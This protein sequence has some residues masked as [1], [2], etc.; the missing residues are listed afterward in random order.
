MKYGTPKPSIGDSLPLHYQEGGDLELT[1]KSSKTE[2]FP[3]QS[4]YDEHGLGFRVQGLGF[5]VQGLG[6]RVQ[7][8][9]SRVQGLGFRV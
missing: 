7:G 6:F 3:E 2:A 8:L 5:R 1:S 9:G 4:K